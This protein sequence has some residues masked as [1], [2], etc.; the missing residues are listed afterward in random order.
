MRVHALKAARAEK[1]KKRAQ[2]PPV[3]SLLKKK[4]LQQE[5]LMTRLVHLVLGQRG[6]S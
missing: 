5:A 4:E 1:K 3:A 2:Q 6:V